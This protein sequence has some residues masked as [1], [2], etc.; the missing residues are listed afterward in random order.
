MQFV[1]YLDFCNYHLERTEAGLE[2]VE[3]KKAKKKRK[4]KKTCPTEIRT[5]DH[6]HSGHTR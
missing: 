3:T 5:R 1:H 4:E 6:T 2:A